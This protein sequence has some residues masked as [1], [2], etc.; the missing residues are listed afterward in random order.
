[1]SDES[2]CVANYNTMMTD[3]GS[4]PVHGKANK[5]HLIALVKM[6]F[7]GKPNT[8]YIDPNGDGERWYGADGRPI[9]DKHNTNHGNPKE[10]PVVPHWHSWG[11]SEDGKW[12]IGKW[13]KDCYEKSKVIG[14]SI[15][16]AIP[17]A[18]V[19]AYGFPNCQY[20]T[21]CDYWTIMCR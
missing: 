16:V 7:R 5:I 6:P 13:H 17:S 8:H 15:L 14:V 12:K 9:K 19:F 4:G 21:A 3:G 2:G 20:A 10:H 18:A 11:E 1:M